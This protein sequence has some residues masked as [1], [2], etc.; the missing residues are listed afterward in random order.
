M[1]K[2]RAALSDT[3]L[4]W[5]NQRTVAVKREACN[6]TLRAA[7]TL[8]GGQAVVT[9]VPCAAAKN[10]VGLWV[11]KWVATHEIFAII[12]LGAAIAVCFNLAKCYFYW[13]TY[14]YAC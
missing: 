3:A 10:I 9:C 14:Y 6:R 8:G 12:L 11:G 4:A 2:K 7:K 13:F 1:D 5:R